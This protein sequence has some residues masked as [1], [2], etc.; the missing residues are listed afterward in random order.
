MLAYVLALAV[1]IG[2]LGVYLAAFFL[3][4]IHRKSDFYWSGVGLFYAAMLWV[5][6]GR[7]TGGV[8]LGQVAVVSLLGWFCWQTLTLRRQ[9]MPVDQQT[10]FQVDTVRSQASSLK[11]NLQS[12]LS[13]P[14]V[15]QVSQKA[16]G[17]FT[18]VKDKVQATIGKSKPP[19]QPPFVKPKPST[20][21]LTKLPQDALETPVDE[22]AKVVIIDNRTT[23]P[24]K[25]S[26]FEAIAKA[27]DS[28]TETSEAMRPHPPSP[29]L[30]DEAVK[31]AEA[32]SIPASP[33]PTTESENP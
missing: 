14:G 7:I 25:P 31:D 9:L 1:G 26:P 18:T 17:L 24:T 2:S 22:D 20:T 19:K 8:L 32:K 5:C 21:P 30:V 11:D 10:P 4:E 16:I 33:P 12:Q 15:S 6:A 3:P 23:P 29:E 28:Q 13:N 27:S